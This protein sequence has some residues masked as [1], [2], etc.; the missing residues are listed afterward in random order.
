[1]SKR[2]A[3]DSFGLLPLA[4]L[5]GL[6][7]TAIAKP[8]SCELHVW[9][10]DYKPQPQLAQK[11]NAFIKIVPFSDEPRSVGW[12]MEPFGRIADNDDATLISALTLPEDTRVMR[13]GD[14]DMR[15][16]KKSKTRLVS[17]NSDCYA[18]LLFEVLAYWPGRTQVDNKDRLTGKFYFRR[19]DTGL[20]PQINVKIGVAA[21][22][23]KSYEDKSLSDAEARAVARQAGLDLVADFSQALVRKT[24]VRN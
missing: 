5:T 9:A 21:V 13:H 6:T 17:G 1:M 11:S 14:G 2:V 22:L 19:F 16:V 12:L 23:T 24:A 10:T 7:S 15:T 4:I 18:D 20:D 8:A 3:I